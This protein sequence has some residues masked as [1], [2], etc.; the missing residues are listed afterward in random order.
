MRE[1]T[2]HGSGSTDRLMLECEAIKAERKDGN[3][4]DVIGEDW[5][6]DHCTKVKDSDCWKEYF[7][8]LRERRENG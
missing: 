3:A 7:R 2:R 8:K 6:H 1:Q 4:M 5:C